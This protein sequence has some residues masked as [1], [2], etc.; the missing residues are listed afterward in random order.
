MKGWMYILKCSNNT[1]YTG[2]TNDL[3]LRLAQHQSGEGSNYTK[4]HSPVEL[5]YYEEFDRID[6]AFNREKQVQ[7]WSS[8]KKKALIEGRLDDLI[9]LS[10]SRTGPSTPLDTS[11]GS[12]TAGNN[13]R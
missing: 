12:A 2:N 13:D 4:K 8:K 11:T 7:K 5:V 10:R 9:E 3:E 6:Y 1:Y